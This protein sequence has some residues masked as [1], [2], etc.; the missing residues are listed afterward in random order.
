MDNIKMQTLKRPV[1]KPNPNVVIEE[2]AF[3]LKNVR[4]TFK[5]TVQTR[6]IESY[7]VE[8]EEESLSIKQ[9]EEENER[10]KEF[11]PTTR[12]LLNAEIRQYKNVFDN[13]VKEYEKKDEY[14]KKDQEE[15]KKSDE[16]LEKKMARY[17]KLQT[18]RKALD[19]DIKVFT[20]EFF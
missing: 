8:E 12:E 17:T 15:L 11:F 9:Q 13:S 2:I 4:N 5:P 14:S 7:D 6:R 19:Q 10:L 18:I 16:I 3:Q 1:E 20:L